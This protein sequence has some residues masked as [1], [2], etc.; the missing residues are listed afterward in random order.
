MYIWTNLQQCLLSLSISLGKNYLLMLLG[1]NL[2]VTLHRLNS[3][4]VTQ[5]QL[6]QQRL[7]VG[8]LRVS[9]WMR[10]YR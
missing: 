1:C 6:Q 2:N 3:D 5:Q 7:K 9:E 8:V 10:S 4:A